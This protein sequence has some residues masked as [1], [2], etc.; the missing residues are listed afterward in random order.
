MMVDTNVAAQ[1]ETDKLR[2]A[3]LQLQQEVE[4]QHGPQQH[5]PDKERFRP[6]GRAK[7]R[8]KK[9]NRSGKAAQ[10]V[11]AA[12]NAAAAAAPAAAAAADEPKRSAYRALTPAPQR[13]EQVQVELLPVQMPKFQHDVAKF[14][15]VL[16]DHVPFGHKPDVA[17]ALQRSVANLC[18]TVLGQQEQLN[19]EAAAKVASADGALQ[20]PAV[21][22]VTFGALAAAGSGSFLSVFVYGPPGMAA[23]LAGK[24]TSAALITLP[25]PFTGL[26]SLAV[27]RAGSAKM[28]EF[29]VLQLQGVSRELD[30]SVV[31]DSLN[32]ASQ[33]GLQLQRV[34]LHM[35]DGGLLFADV[36]DLVGHW[37]RKDASVR[38]A[39]MAPGGAPAQHVQQQQ[40]FI[41]VMRRTQT[42]V[43]AWV[44]DLVLKSAADSSTKASVSD[45]ARAAA[46][47]ATAATAQVEA[48]AASKATDA[49]DPTPSNAADGST[50]SSSG[51]SSS[52]GSSGSTACGAVPQEPVPLSWAAVVQGSAAAP[53]A[54]ATAAA[55]TPAPA[56]P[57]ATPA[58][59]AVDDHQQQQQQL[60]QEAPK[61]QQQSPE[62]Q[63]QTEQQPA[64]TVQKQTVPKQQ[65]QQQREPKQ[66]QQ[67]QQPQQQQQQQQQQAQ[68][69]LLQQQQQPQQQQQ[70]RQ[71]QPTEQPLQPAKP[72]Q[73][74]QKPKQQQVQVQ[75][76]AG[77]LTAAARPKSTLE[78]AS[79]LL[80]TPS[81]DYG[82]VT[83]A[84]EDGLLAMVYGPCPEY[85]ATPG[86]SSNSSTPAQRGK[87][88]AGG[89]REPKPST[90]ADALGKPTAPTCSDS[91]SR[92]GSSK[93]GSDTTL[94]PS[95]A[96]A[97]APMP[98]DM[99]A[100]V[101]QQQQQ[102]QQQQ[103]QSP[104]Q[105]Q[106][107][108]QQQQPDLAEEEPMDWS[109]VKRATEQAE[110]PEQ[111][112]G[113]KPKA[114]AAPN[115]SSGTPQGCC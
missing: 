80:D 82:S 104:P 16:P 89:G 53:V 38:V 22:R 14:T 114:G 70:Q 96:A 41:R 69:M 25:E 30:P 15:V 11:H 61:Q 40:A 77:S 58:G 6:Y 7:P 101:L 44:L 65:Q 3:K 106:Q 49:S 37:D 100:G 68:S 67:Q 102:R 54:A 57:T 111:R 87:S 45:A 81:A 88:R 43:P 83:A 21:T 26:A 17:R 59:C 50:P 27:Q 24:L 5:E 46:T 92:D 85:G 93:G 34:Q 13:S 18:R 72:D 8:G 109:L 52:G 97:S 110:L 31:L 74:Q 28:R 75:R 73:Q 48:V 90:T 9:P 23:K 35:D 1:Q 4:Q 47:T 113:K 79:R 2:E 66:Q 19:P 32:R 12:P 55:E 33:L 39:L 86:S 91:S 10:H 51:G 98:S 105:Q 95:C 20:A 42:C 63:P 84:K 94:P 60:Q 78:K 56:V 62:Q 115:A 76:T 99:E 36:W 107:Q 29:R 64:S 103:Q 108:Q 71:Q 112:A